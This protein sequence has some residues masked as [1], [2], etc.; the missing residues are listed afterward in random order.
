LNIYSRNKNVAYDSS[1]SL[2]DSQQSFAVSN[3][4]EFEITGYLQNIKFQE[5]GNDSIKALTN[6]QILIICILRA[7]TYYHTSRFIN[8]QVQQSC[9]SK[10]HI[11]FSNGPRSSS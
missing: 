9:L 1:S 7:K 5:I 8:K 6:K 11:S 4:N 3:N 2:G 10:S